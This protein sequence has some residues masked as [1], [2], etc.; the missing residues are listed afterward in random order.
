MT[1]S[2]P[3]S[4]RALRFG[5]TQ[6]L[7]LSL[8]LLFVP[9]TSTLVNVTVDDQLG[10]RT[11]GLIPEY[12]PNDGTWHVGSP[13]EDCSTC[14]LTP[15]TFDLTQV[16]EETW[17]DATYSPPRTPATITVQFT[18]TAVYVFNILPNTLSNTTT[19]VN[20]SFSIDGTDVGTFTR[21]PDSSS[22]ILYNQLV[23]QNTALTDVAHTLIMTAGGDSKSLVLFDYLLYTTQSNDTTSTSASTS[24]TT[25]S[26]P[27]STSTPIDSSLD[28][29]SPSSTPVGA[30]VGAVIGSLICLLGMV[31]VACHLRR[32]IRARSEPPQTERGHESNHTSGPD[33]WGSTSEGEHSAFLLPRSRPR[34]PRLLG[35]SPPGDP[36]MR[37]LSD[38]DGAPAAAAHDKLNL[39]Q[40][41]RQAG[42]AH[43][44]VSGQDT[45]TNTNTTRPPRSLVTAGTGAAG[46]PSTADWS[47]K[48]RA[49]LTRRLE[50]LQR[51]RSVL[52]SEWAPSG[53]SRS[54]VVSDGSGAETG[55]ETAIREMEAEIVQLRGVLA[56]LSAR[57]ADSDERRGDPEPL[58]AYAE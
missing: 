42:L 58:P 20:I 9:V 43:S 45:N 6:P 12:L 21:S 38:R 30:I 33:H 44:D 2:C 39:S 55:T 53:R 36:A 48:R 50:T 8:S 35:V 51:T 22:T 15:S 26:S 41:H 16:Y 18:G 5:I 24:T 46:S 10:D 13:A 3:S 54:E 34:P 40:S 37:S 31:I 11:T 47:S 4:Y 56:A 49:E 1:S 32:R 57:L 28:Q 7:L 29:S 52:S 27:T 17:H 14:K 23:Y 19:V 25:Q